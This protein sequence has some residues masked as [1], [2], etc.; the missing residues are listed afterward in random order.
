[1]A[2]DFVTILYES[3]KTLQVSVFDLQG[4]QVLSQLSDFKQNNKAL[5]NVS[6]LQQGMY[7]ITLQNNVE[8]N[9]FTT[10]LLRN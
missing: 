2:S 1:P 10:R 8:Q 5:L 6:A 7:F 9:L 4:R 3:E